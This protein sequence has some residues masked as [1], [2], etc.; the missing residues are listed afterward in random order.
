MQQAARFS[1]ARFSDIDDEDQPRAVAHRLDLG[2][3]IFHRRLRSVRHRR[4]AEADHQEWHLGPLEIAVVGATALVSAALGSADVR[5]HRRRVRAQVHLRLRSARAGRGCDR[6]GVFAQHLV[7]DRVPLHPGPGHRRRLSGQR[8]DRERVRRREGARPHD[9]DRLRDAGGGLDR[10]AAARDRA[11]RGGRVQRSRRGACCSPPA[12]FRRS[13]SSGRAVIS[14]RRRAS[15]SCRRR[16]PT[17][18]GEAERRIANGFV[19]RCTKR[20]RHDDH[21]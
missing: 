14:R 20:S 3:G 15:R 16:P 1:A 17:S 9:L 7:A 2:H 10:R 12:R 21:S 6:V 4:R 8:D 5:P 13:P 11:A 19:R 18:V